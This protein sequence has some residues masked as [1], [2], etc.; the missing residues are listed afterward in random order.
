ML[1]YILFLIFDSTENTI[2]SSGFEFLWARLTVSQGDVAW[3]LWSKY[4]NSDLNFEY[5][6]TLYVAIG[7][8]IWSTFSGITR[9]NQELWV[10]SHYGS[11]LTYAIDYPLD[12]IFDG[13]NVT[14]TPFSEGLIAGGVIGTIIFGFLAGLISGYS[15]KQVKI[16][17]NKQ[18]HLQSALWSCYFVFCVF[19]WLNGGEIVQLF[20]ISVFISLLLSWLLL[21]TVKSLSNLKIVRYELIN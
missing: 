8:R 20:H 11:L 12:G 5:T 3:Y 15:Y 18:N 16:G 7:D 21:K 9:E 19:S 17:I 2:Y 13:H 14:G 10:L 6:K 1:V 4:L